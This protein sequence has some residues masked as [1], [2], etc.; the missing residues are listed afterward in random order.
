MKKLIILLLFNLYCL[1]VSSQG[2]S[3]EQRLSEFVGKINTFNNLYPQEKVYLHFDNTGYYKGEA[4]WFKAYVVSSGDNK[5]TNMS[6]VLYVDF[7]NPAGFVV[8]SK[9]LKIEDGQAR[10]EFQIADSINSGFFEVRAYT[11]YMLNFGENCLFSRVFPVYDSPEKAGDYGNKIMT[12]REKHNMITYIEKDADKKVPQ[13]YK[14]AFYPESGNLVKGLASRV[15]FKAIDEY[16]QNIEIEGKIFRKQ[17]EQEAVASFASVHEGMGCFD[18]T[19]DD[20]EYVA[21]FYYNGNYHRAS[22]PKVSEEG[23]V[24]NVNNLNDKHLLIQVQKTSAINPDTLGL[25]ILCWGKVHVFRT[26]HPEDTLFSQ[27]IAKESLPTGVNQLRLFDKNGSVIAERFI[28]IDHQDYKANSLTCKTD[29]ESYEPYAPI[30]INFQATEANNQPLQTTF[31]VAVRD[32]ESEELTYNDDNI[33]TNLLLSS[34][35]KG[36]IKNPAYYFKQDDTGSRYKLD[37]LMMVQGWIRYPFR[38]GKMK[39]E[40]EKGLG[41][42]GKVLTAP[43]RL[44]LRKEMGNVQLKAWALNDSLS[45]SGTT[46]ADSKGRFNFFINDDVFG[47]YSLAIQS[48][49]LRKRGKYKDRWF[50]KNSNILLDR[51]EYLEPK[52]YTFYE[53]NIPFPSG[54]N[55]STPSFESDTILGMRGLHLQEVAVIAKRKNRKKFKIE[56]Y[57]PAVTLDMWDEMDRQIDLHGRWLNE[58]RRHIT[59]LPPS[60]PEFDNQPVPADRCVK[61]F[62]RIISSSLGMPTSTDIRFLY[63]KPPQG[64]RMYYLDYIDKIVVYT[65]RNLR[66]KTVYEKPNESWIADIVCQYIPYKNDYHRPNVDGIRYTKLYGYAKPKEFYHPD[67]S[68]VRLP[69]ERDF[70]RTLYWNPDV[71]TDKAGKATISF[72]NNGSCKEINIS[73][74]GLTNEGVPMVFSE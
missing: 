53:T 35:L 15:A 22:L 37:L 41:F 51:I 27:R 32:G 46:V 6:H 10:G 36:F 19:P 21:E 64:V 14:I 7:L 5:F 45:I 23:Y 57:A 61:S 11:R 62:G 60:M 28:F 68:I 47:S 24:M 4:I 63:T 38:K 43:D 56:D 12:E 1:S 67:Y 44:G 29:R 39:Y 65:D 42:S 55:Y 33:V 9:K 20:S 8:E 71:K 72:Y 58:C 30:R 3:E 66:D 59:D 2:K 70:R 26:I 13:P 17:R 69:D 52:A 74:E 54:K 49:E 40:I 73:A 25:A 48:N 50:I 18:F 34:E 31:S 16:G